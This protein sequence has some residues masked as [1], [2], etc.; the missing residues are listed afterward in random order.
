V[1]VIKLDECDAASLRRDCRI[2]AFSFDLIVPHLRVNSIQRQQL[3]VALK[4]FYS[5]IY[6]LECVLKFK[7]PSALDDASLT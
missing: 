1:K 7:I 4:Y 5:S 2:F 3:V 6:I